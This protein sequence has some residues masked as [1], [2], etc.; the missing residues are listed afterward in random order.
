M[1][2]RNSVAWT[3]SGSGPE[4]V[5]SSGKGKKGK[6]DR[7]AAE[8][9]NAWSC[10]EEFA[11]QELCCEFSGRRLEFG[12]QIYLV[13]E[14]MQDL[15]G[16]RVVRPVLHFVTNKKNR[17]E[18]SHALALALKTS[19]AVQ[20]CETD[21]PEKYLRGETISCDPSLKGWTLITYQGQP[22]GWGKADRGIMKNHY[23]K[24]LRV[25]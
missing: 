5:R 7:A 22:M 25:N 17:F 4:A 10:Y 9:A 14:E 24:G 19:E 15:K 8:G 21:E 1:P 20:V 23:P 6:K 18:P 3:A 2:H 12:E 16:R 11:A 13:P